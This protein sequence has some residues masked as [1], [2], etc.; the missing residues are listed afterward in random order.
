MSGRPKPPDLV[1]I[2]E[3]TFLGGR[4]QDAIS[5]LFQVLNR[6]PG[7]VRASRA[8]GAVF[9]SLGRFDE[10]RQAF[11]RALAADEGD[12]GARRDLALS[13]YSLSLFGEAREELERLLVRHSGEYPY[14]SLLSA[15]EDAAERGAGGRGR[16]PVF[17]R[18]GDEGEGGD[19]EGPLD[20]D[21][22]MQEEMIRRCTDRVRKTL[23]VFLTIASD[24]EMDIL[25]P[26]LSDYFDLRRVMSFKYDVYLEAA[27]EADFVWL[28]GLADSSAQFVADR[29]AVEG[30]KVALRLSRED[31]LGGAARNVP[32]VWADA[33]FFDSFSLRDLFLAGNPELRAGTPLE[34][35]PRAIDT[36]LYTYVPRHGRRKIAA[37]ASPSLGPAEFVLLLEAY[38]ILLRHHPGLELHVSVGIRNMANEPHVQQFLTENG[39]GFT[40]FFHGHGE[41]LQ[42]FL[43][44]CHCFLSVETCPGGP[45]ALEALLM[46]L[47]PLIRTSP[48]ASELYPE[49]C[50][51]RN[52]G[53]IRALFDA[54]PDP[55]RISG[56]LKDIHR[57]RA[58][59]S[60]YVRRFIALGW[61]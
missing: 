35:V 8:L 6:D 17:L 43:N 20:P 61:F 34:V 58:V 30:R 13:L 32:F 26:G 57:P 15:V 39:C 38:L 14:W 56:L 47:K 33:L 18:P 45:G 16:R 54:P 55:V 59:V 41:A 21:A 10:A 44:G 2:A 28:E 7:D 11:Q 1:D 22:I 50:L 12:P 49:S 27:R 9:H 5:M 36:R 53:E 24:R 25:A 51:W 29:G 60:Q 19:Q 23:A 4:T 52:L 42:S 37:V 3:M 48:G 31:V 46:G 40:V